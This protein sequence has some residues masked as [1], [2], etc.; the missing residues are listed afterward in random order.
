[1]ILAD[2]INRTPPKTQA[3][4]A[5]SHARTAG[6]GR[7]CEAFNSGR[8]RSSCWPR[9][10]PSNKKAPIRCPK[11][12]RTASCSRSLW[13]TPAS[14]TS[15]RSRGAR[16]HG[17][18]AEVEPCWTA[19]EIIELQHRVREVPV[20]DHVIRY[21]LSLCGKR[22]LAIPG[23]PD[24]VEEMIGWGAGPRAVQ[25]LI[26][27]G[28]A[29]ALAARSHACLDRR[30]SGAWPSPCCG[31]AWWSTSPPKVKAVTQTM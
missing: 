21:A 17:G 12:S 18:Q 6:H 5:G 23:T 28:K 22:A 7:A 27:G 15:S 19:E 4:L 1:M 10:T 31:I 2:E 11:R 29:R 14:R 16:P 9:R 13:S 20:S 26:L 24:F 8:S 3:A 25:F 30:Y